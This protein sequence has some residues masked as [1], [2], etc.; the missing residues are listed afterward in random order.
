MRRRRWRTVVLLIGCTL[1]VLIFVAFITSGWSQLAVQLPAR[2][3]PGLAVTGGSLCIFFGLLWE[4]L[5][6]EGPSWPLWNHWAWC[7]SDSLRSVEAPLY[8]M[9]LAVAIPTLLIWR[10]VVKFPSGHCRRC[11]YNLTGLTE[12]RCPECGAGFGEA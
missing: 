1:C 5:W 11:G 12:A 3:G 2:Y 6:G 8:G 10:F 7:H 9:F 4:P